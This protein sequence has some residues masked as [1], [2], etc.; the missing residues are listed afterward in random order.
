VPDEV[1]PLDA[2]RVE[3]RHDVVDQ[4]RDGIRLGVRLGR[5]RPGAVSPLVG[6]QSTEAAGD[7][8]LGDRVPRLPVL[9]KPVQEDDRR[10]GRVAAVGDVEDQ[11]VARVLGDGAHD[12]H[13]GAIL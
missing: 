13:R 2:R 12:P 6:S 9:G 7:E 8:S 1:S 11:P 5:A 4:L 10:V 3:Q